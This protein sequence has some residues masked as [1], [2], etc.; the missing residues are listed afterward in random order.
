MQGTRTKGRTWVT[1]WLKWSHLRTNA[2]GDGS[3]TLI[4]FCFMVLPRTHKTVLGT[5]RGGNST[6]GRS[7][8][9]RLSPQ[10]GEEALNPSHLPPEE[11]GESGTRRRTVDGQGETATPHWSQSSEFFEPGPGET[12]YGAPGRNLQQTPPRGSLVPRKRRRGGCFSSAGGLPGRTCCSGARLRVSGS[13]SPCTCLLQQARAGIGVGREGRCRGCRNSQSLSPLT[14]PSFGALNPSHLPPEES[15]TRR[16]TVDGQGETA[17]P[18]W[19]QSSEFFE[20]GPGETQYGAP[21]RNLQQ[22]PPRGSL[23]PR[24]RRRGGCFSS[25]G[26]LPGRTCCSGARLRVSGSESPCTCLLQQARAGIGVG[27]EG[28][29][30]GCRNSQSLSPLTHPSFGS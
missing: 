23:V 9:L 1:T 10:R 26:G 17:T 21:G 8:P 25:A 16:R 22:T 30:R 13:E 7:V 28:R 12:Q 4:V 11:A 27:R 18:H 15:G 19:S 14:H 24:K 20:P 2:T 5:K 3:D 6:S 29:C